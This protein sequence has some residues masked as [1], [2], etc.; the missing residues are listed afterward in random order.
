MSARARV[1]RVW[2]CECG[3]VFQGPLAAIHA[4]EHADEML[5][6]SIGHR[7]A[8]LTS[9]SRDPILPESIPDSE[10]REVLGI[11]RAFLNGSG[12]GDRDGGC[13]GAR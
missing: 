5:M 13:G 10:A 9:S 11:V 3:A 4:N 12:L 1:F 7:I 6:E 8:C 2:G